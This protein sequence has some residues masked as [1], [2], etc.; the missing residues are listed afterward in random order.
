[1]PRR[2]RAKLLYSR[3]AH[4]EA[5]VG[6]YFEAFTEVLAEI[7]ER[8]DEEMRALLLNGPSCTRSGRRA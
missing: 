7:A 3:I 2:A 5:I 6:P 8:S 1:V 4:D